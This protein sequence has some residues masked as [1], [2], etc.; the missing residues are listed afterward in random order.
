[1]KR[2]RIL[3][4]DDN[5]AITDILKMNFELLGYEVMVASDGEEAERK[6]KAFPPDLMLLD[7]MMPKKNGYKV[8]RDL[9]K[10]PQLV[11]IPII[12]LTAKNLKEDVYWGYDCGA[13]AYVTKPYDPRQ[14]ELLV[15]QLIQ[16]A[17]TGRRS[18]S[19]TG[20]PDASRVE[21]EYRARLEAGASAQ[22]L[23]ASFSRE[24]AEAFRRKYGVPR[25]KDLLHRTAWMLYEIVRDVTSAGV[26]G[27]DSDDRF[28]VTLHPEEADPLKAKSQ[29]KLHEMIL[30]CY[31]KEDQQRGRLLEPGMGPDKGKE[32]PLIALQWETLELPAQ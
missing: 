8:C 28:F 31:D 16:E 21:A 29:Q 17:V 12:L 2:Q 10:D 30:S 5:R 15:G 14:L 23:R 7:V 3:I 9:K 11:R 13:D 24:P 20:L 18:T 26:L 25:F 32:T 4:A 6:F 27:Q 1:M 19:W 22:L